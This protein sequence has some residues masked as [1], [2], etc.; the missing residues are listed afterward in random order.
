MSHQ[1]VKR[2]QAVATS[3]F[4]IT[5]TSHNAATKTITGTFNGI[6]ED[7]ASVNHTITNGQFT[8]VYP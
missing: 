2:I 3:L 7:E 6:V 1:P 4:T 5:V 8:A